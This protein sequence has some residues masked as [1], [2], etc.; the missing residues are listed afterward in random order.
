M[1]RRT[2]GNQYVR[3][4]PPGCCKCGQKQYGSDTDNTLHTMYCKGWKPGINVV[5][6]LP[7]KGG[8]LETKS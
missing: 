7:E 8:E 2:S 1:N 6:W 3:A 5:I 4:W